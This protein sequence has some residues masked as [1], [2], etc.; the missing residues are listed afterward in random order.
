MDTGLTPVASTISGLAILHGSS[1]GLY[2]EIDSQVLESAFDGG[3]LNST[4]GQGH[5]GE[6][7]RKLP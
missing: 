2:L 5:Y 3:V 1:V 6:S 4:D 7:V